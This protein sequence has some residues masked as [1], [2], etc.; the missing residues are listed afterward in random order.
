MIRRGELT[1]EAYRRRN[2]VERCANLFKQRRG[3]ATRYEERAANYRA[4]VIIPSLMT[5]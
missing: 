5:A 2:V 3:A 1:D 4:M